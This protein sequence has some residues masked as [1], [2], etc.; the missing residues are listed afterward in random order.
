MAVYWRF[1]SLLVLSNV[2]SVSPFSLLSAKALAEPTST[3]SSRSQY[4][5]RL[6]FVACA[7]NC[8]SLLHHH[9]LLPIP[10]CREVRNTRWRVIEDQRLMPDPR[11]AVLF[12]GSQL[13]NGEFHFAWPGV[14][15]NTDPPLARS[16][17][18]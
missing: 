15:F 10:A 6:T 13:G 14:S 8:R 5:R 2:L 3:H 4:D 17:R 1:E 7:Y 11:T 16:F 9:I 12:S 18:R